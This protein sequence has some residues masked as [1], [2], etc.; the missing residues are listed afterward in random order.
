M[1][2][3]NFHAMVIA[4]IIAGVVGVFF[5]TG[6]LSPQE[7]SAPKVIHIETDG[8]IWLE[9]A[10][11]GLNCIDRM[12]KNINRFKSKMRTASKAEYDELQKELEKFPPQPYRNNAIEALS[13]A[14]N[15]KK[16]C[17]FHATWGNMQLGDYTSSACRSAFELEVSYRC[18]Q[19]GRYRR[20]SAREGQILNLNCD[21][22]AT[23]EGS[24]N[25]EDNALGLP[26]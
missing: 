9:E 21:E 4:G 23:G 11:W 16:S 22:N 15:S 14:C 8:T 1:H 7:Q 12:Q 10:S 24:S 17:E 2:N 19:Y 18:E 5:L 20:E 6:N 25:N 3:I 26:L 13:L